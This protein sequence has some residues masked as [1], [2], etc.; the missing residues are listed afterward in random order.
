MAEAHNPLEQFEII[1]LFDFD[2]LGFDLAYTNSSLALTIGVVA[3]I[4]FVVGGMSRATIVPGRWQSMV[5]MFY[6]FIAS[7]LNEAVGP[8]ARK[9]FPFVFTLFMFI[10]F[11][12]VSGMIPRPLSFTP[13]S[14]IAITL[15]LAGFV[16]IG[17]TIF[18]FMKNGL[19]FF[20]LFMPSGIPIAMAPFLIVIELISYLVRP[21]SLSVRLFANMTAG[22]I[23]L[24]VI[25]GFAASLGVFAI[26]P[27]L[28]NVALTGLEF[29]VAVL[30]AYVF[31]MLSC[32]YLNDAYHCDH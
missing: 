30:Q 11:V 10:L 8:E 17:I 1:K 15:G 32:I 16:F 5:E 29:L 31:T 21:M 20:K 19:G 14:H 4:I 3:A 22:H 24:K 23:M 2:L 7:M 26:G 12:N 18:G 9:F 6:E 28:F 25:A 27:I 13:T